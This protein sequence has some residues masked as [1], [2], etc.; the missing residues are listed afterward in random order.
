MGAADHGN[1]AMKS[2]SANRDVSRFLRI[3][4]ALAWV[5]LCASLL[6]ATQQSESKKASAAGTGSTV[7]AKSFDTPQQAAAALVDA[8]DKFDVLELIE[9]F[10][11]DGDDVVLS[12]EYPQDQK[13]AAD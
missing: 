7:A 1:K 5:C 6:S 10:G 12:G 2:T 9:I 11:P 13:R 4:K 8:A 3:A